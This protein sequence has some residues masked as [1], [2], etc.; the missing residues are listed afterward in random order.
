MK[1]QIFTQLRQA[2]THKEHHQ[3]V[4]WHVFR[5]LSEAEAYADNVVLCD[6]QYLVGGVDHDSVGSLW[7]IGVEVD[8]LTK[9]GNLGSINKHAA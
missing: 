9:W 7:W 5:A 8:D 4:F 1:S 2:P 6:G 3:V